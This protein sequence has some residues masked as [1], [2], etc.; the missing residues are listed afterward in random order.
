VTPEIR[1]ERPADEARIEAV[2][3]AAFGRPD[4]A[5]LVEAL[6]AA[7]A[8]RLSLVAAYDD[9]IVG[10][11]AFSPVTV[12]GNADGIAVWGLAPLAIMPLH[13]KA[14]IGRMLVKAGLDQA[15]AMG[16]QAAVVLGDPAYYGRFGFVPAGLVGLE[17]EHP[18]PPGAFQ[19]TAL[20]ERALTRLDGTVAY[21][22]AFGAV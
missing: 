12:S 3:T 14:G 15:E 22:A 16:A 17:W 13:Q 20:A 6:R 1:P 19:V 8:L 18:C 7:G 10:H 2:V 4:E 11:V 5:R 21:H 9:D